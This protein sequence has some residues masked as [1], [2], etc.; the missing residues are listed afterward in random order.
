MEAR[1]RVGVEDVQA[2][3][4]QNVLQGL[5]CMV[6]LARSGNA[7]GIRDSVALTGWYYKVV[8]LLGC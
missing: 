4:V 3:G 5:L 1:A 7:V 6:N 8:I 2:Y